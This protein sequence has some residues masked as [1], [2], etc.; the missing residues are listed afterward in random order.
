MEQLSIERKEI[1][2]TNKNKTKKIRRFSW[3]FN[4]YSEK[5]M[6][7]AFAIIIIIAGL[8]IYHLTY[9]EHSGKTTIT[10]YASPAFRLLIDNGLGPAFEN[11]TNI[12]VVGSY[13]GGGEQYYK[14]KITNQ[15][16]CDLFL[17]AAPLYIEKGYAEG[18]FISYKTQHEDEINDSLKSR[19]VTYNNINGRIWY[20]VAWTPLVEIYSIKNYVQAPDIVRNKNVSFGLSHPILANNGIYVALMLESFPE[21]VTRDIESRCKY[22]PAN[23]QA[24][25]DGV[26][27][28]KYDIA[29]GYEGTVIEYKKKGY[30]ID[31]DVTLVDGKKYCTP[32][33]VSAGIVKKGKTDLALKFIEWML[34][35]EGQSVFQKFYYRPTCAEYSGDGVKITNDVKFVNYNWSKTEEIDSI[36]RKHVLGG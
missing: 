11:K 6:A 2:K 12:H 35:E 16:D 34:S 27:T 36:L 22:Q 28:G 30:P 19:E 18:L 7:C 25:I 23:A 4:L 29:F 24:T 33:L 15:T 17:H 20:A 9:G 31:S 21:E 13:L 8:S 5:G 10:V 32:V 3:D 1:K 14:I 26:C